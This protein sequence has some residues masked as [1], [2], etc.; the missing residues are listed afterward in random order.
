M[1]GRGVDVFLTHRPVFV[2]W[3]TDSLMCVVG[4]CGRIVSCFLQHVPT[5]V[6]A[7]VMIPALDSE[8]VASVRAR[9]DGSWLALLLQLPE[10]G[11]VYDTFNE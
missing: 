3:D 5:D 2:A 6:L 10:I 7:S 1:T 4:V 8:R 9:S 11:K